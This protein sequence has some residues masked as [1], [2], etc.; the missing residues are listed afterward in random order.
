MIKQLAHV[1]LLTEDLAKTAAFYCEGLGL[2]KVFDFDKEGRWFG[3]YIRTGNDS[4]IE[5]FEGTPGDPGSIIHLCLEVDDID[6]TINELRQRGIE[7]GDK[8]LGADNNYQAWLEDPN[9]V[10]I[11]LMQYLPDNCQ[12]TGRTCIVNW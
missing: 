8:K 6:A 2:E 10:K 3:F 12:R 9:G 5:V 7:V 11:E 4:F 1:C